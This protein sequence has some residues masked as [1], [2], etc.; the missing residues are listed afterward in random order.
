M[1]TEAAPADAA[2][3]DA[4]APADAA[5]APDA[6]TADDEEEQAGGDKVKP[7]TN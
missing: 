7:A 5:A 6:A 3:A 2:A 4:A 1:P